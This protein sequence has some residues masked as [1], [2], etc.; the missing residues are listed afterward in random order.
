VAPGDATRDYH[1][2]TSVSPETL[3]PLVLDLPTFPAPCKVYPDGLPEVVLPADWTAPRGLD[4]AA[5]SRL[6]HLSAGV[7]RT[8]AR[9][10]GR[11]YHFRA[12]GSAGGRSPYEAYVCARGVAGLADGV[13]WYDPVGH[14]LRRVGPAPGGDATTL[15]LTGIPWR[16]GWQYGERGLRHIYWD[17]GSVLAQALALAG[18]SACLYTR[19]PDA[20]VTRLV[21]ADGVHEWPVALVALAPGEPAIVPG[22]DAAA[23]QVD[24]RPPREYPLVTRAH[25][26]GDV[27]VLGEPWPDDP[28]AFAELE[29][30]I[31]RRGSTRIMAPVAVS[32]DL[33]D[34][35]LGAGLH[36]RRFVAVHAV[37]GVAPG[38]YEW[39]ELVRPGD[40]REELYH[41]CMEQA[42]GR[43]AAFVV[44][45]VADLEALDDRG[46]REAQLGAGIGEG[47]IHLAAYAGGVG[48]TGMTFYDSA[49]EALL[50]E[51]LA[52][53]L[54]T[55]VGVPAYRSRRGGPPRAPVAI[56]TMRPR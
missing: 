15:V 16:T 29:D 25:H 51:P 32:R 36:G 54:F 18:P 42:L 49:L 52:G 3:P 41:V 30:V 11:F 23:G 22:G 8:S 35:C 17:V 27:D 13:H 24:V 14:A 43:D 33:L 19:F 4:L 53:L 2:R 26:A 50:G 6:L 5:L 44:M 34:A 45:A 37:D 21:G 39:P 7:V 10:D 1:R 40:L 12:A 56:G 46:Y 47:R 38:L 31:L 20:A 28:P 9:P 55:C 48:A